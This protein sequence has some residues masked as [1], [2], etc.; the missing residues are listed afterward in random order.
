[1]SMLM[2]WRQVNRVGEAEDDHSV[3]MYIDDNKPLSG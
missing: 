3:S 2:Y 1:M